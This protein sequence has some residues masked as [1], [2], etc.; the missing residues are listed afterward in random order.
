[1]SDRVARIVLGVVSGLALLAALGVDLPTA[2][3][4]RFWSD[5]A[6]Y[7]AMAGSLAFDHDLV[8]GAEDLARVRSL[9]PGGPQGVFLK[10]V[11]AASGTARLV[12]AKAALYPAAAWPLARLLG[13]DRGLLVLNALALGL[14]LGLG[15]VEL[16]R[17]DAAGR[18]LAGVLAVLVLGIA[19]V[20][21]LWETPELLNLALVTAGLVAFRRER[22]ALAALALGLAVYSKPTHLAAALPL[23]LAPLFSSGLGLAGRVLESARRAALV[24]V[25]AA[26]AF[27]VGWLATGELNYQGGER[28]T[29]YDRYPFDPGVSFDS[30][31]V[32][33]T[34]DHVGPLVAGRDEDKQSERTA[35]AREPGRAARARSC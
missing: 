10:R 17:R 22:P 3:D 24:A 32:W 2:A 14:A 26:A 21:L 29:F 19:P 8:F 16:R 7:H 4:H 27:G 34:T 12:Y 35:P 33:M 20:Y 31:G 28:K 18:A 9:Y 30:A 23:L 1:M 6:T 25:V 15:Y 13:V 5:G 11:A